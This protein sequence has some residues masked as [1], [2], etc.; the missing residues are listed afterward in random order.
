MSVVIILSSSANVIVF[1]DFV[2]SN[3]KGLVALQKGRAVDGV[4]SMIPHQLKII[5]VTAL[6][7]RQKELQA[8]LFCTDFF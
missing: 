2:L 1:F 4:S 5:I 8:T 7:F 6:P 3:K